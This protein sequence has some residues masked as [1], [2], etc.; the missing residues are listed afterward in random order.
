L[1]DLVRRSLSE[2]GTSLRDLDAVAVSVGPGSFTGLRV[3]LSFAKGIA[4]SAGLPLVGVETLEALAS[5]APSEFSRIAAATDAR[6]GETYLGLFRRGSAGLERVGVDVA[7][8]PGEAAR[9]IL[10]GFAGAPGI[11]VG[12]AAEAYPE[13]FQPLREH[14]IRLAPFREIHPRGSMVAAVGERS[15]RRGGEARAD[16][17]VPRYVRAPAAEINLERSRAAPEVAR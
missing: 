15:L 6:K 3:G 4:Y 14:S 7:L 8:K 1:P 12:D 5:L 11:V 17:V 9:R 2:A 16:R 10:E 13:A